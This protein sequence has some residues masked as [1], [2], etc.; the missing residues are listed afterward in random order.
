[1]ENKKQL[2]I[3]PPMSEALK[4]LHEVLEGIAAD[5]NIEISLIDDLKEL[6]Q[7]IG[8]SGQC[9]ILCANAKKCATF[10][11]D[12]RFVI[13]KSHSKTMLFTPKEIPAKTLIK[14][15]KVGL[16][17]SILENSP[18][19][20]L[21]YKIKL[22]LRSIRT[23]STEKEKE[24]VK[25]ISD[26][27][28]DTKAVS[29]E[30]DKIREKTS[31]ETSSEQEVEH[32]KKFEAESENVIDYGGSLKG[33]IK[34]QEDAI[35]THWKSK[36]KTEETVLEMQAGEENSKVKTEEMNDI[37]LYYRGKRKKD[38]D[39]L[40][41]DEEEFQRL[42]KLEQEM[43]EA[44]AAKR[45][46]NFQ[47]EY[48]NDYIRQKKLEDSI[49]YDNDLLGLKSQ[50][51]TTLDLEET[52]KEKSA[53]IE[54]YNPLEGK[55]TKAASSELDL[56]AGDKK[57][58]EK[59]VEDLGGHYKGKINTTTLELEEDYKEEKEAIQEEYDNSEL[60]LDKKESIELELTKEK[61]KKDEEAV[62]E[63]KSKKH[64]GEVDHLSDDKMN[65]EGSTDHIETFMGGVTTSSKK[66]M[67]V[68]SEDTELDLKSTEEYNSDENAD[69]SNDTTTLDL[70]DSSKKNKEKTETE[71]YE[72]DLSLKKTTNTELEFDSDKD[73]KSEEDLDSDSRAGLRRE[74]M[75][76]L[77]EESDLNQKVGEKYENE[78]EMNLKKMSQ[79]KLDIEKAEAE[80]NHG[81]V[82]KIDT[83]YRSGDSKKVEHS[84]DNLTDKRK[85]VELAL[86]KGLKADINLEGNGK[87]KDAGEITID[88]R[89]LKQE[90][91]LIN[92]GETVGESNA[93]SRSHS[94]SGDPEDEGSFKVIDLNPRGLDLSVALL[95]NIFQKNIKPK[96]IYAQLAEDILNKY[97]GVTVFWEYK[98]SE[99][100]HTEVYN[101]YNEI[102]APTLSVEKKE[103]WPEYKKDT[104]LFQHFQTRSMYTWRCPE[105]VE[106]GSIWEDVELPSWAK[107]EL[108]DKRVELAFPYFDG[109]DRMGLALVNFHEGIRPEDEHA[110][111]TT[112]EMARH[113]LL[114]T[115]Q[116]QKA[117]EARSQSEDETPIEEQPNKVLG[118]FGGLFGKKKVG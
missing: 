66:E 60:D 118:F 85:D 71:E 23:A 37:D 67:N 74:K 28:T 69:Q 34:P 30:E 43:Q 44:E 75:M 5:E 10:L 115:I 72:K 65:G 33:K 103:W 79:S 89:K 51:E 38:S 101:S 106:K 35:E 48:G 87:G 108:G 46:S 100:K 47:E 84:W 96:T 32:K 53:L 6:G 77:E 2:I 93:I 98:A 56:E 90:F 45:K 78:N 1:M 91:D 94:A 58:K 52:E 16:T 8:S 70:E 27:S 11:Q 83:F 99:K 54:E 80:R 110:I 82:D 29:Q 41:T 88:Y 3:V 112:L 31:T 104:T 14:F 92:R 42:K 40:E 21:L 22:Q 39:L 55:R 17:E 73:K 24:V 26:A 20:T 97:S 9:L 113:L 62:E 61:K 105:I 111:L 76:L 7:F 13:S 4:K 116:R 50:K 95:L 102:P 114:D 64:D 86:L 117:P 81:K 18:P 36:R 107:N 25:N 59:E 49:E 68:D 19:K 57:T 63:S 109:V 15:T 12:N